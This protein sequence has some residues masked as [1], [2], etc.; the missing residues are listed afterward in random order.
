M[1]RLT[2]KDLLACKGARKLT[3]VAVRNAREAAACEAAGI[4]ILGASR[5]TADVRAIRAAAPSCFLIVGIGYGR[6]N[7]VEDALEV[8]FALLRDGVDAIYCGQSMDYVEALAKEG[9]PVVGHVGMVPY[10]RT[11]SGGFKAVGKTL[12]EALALFDLVKAYEN[13]GA[14]AVEM[15]LVPERVAAA[16]TARVKL[17]TFGMGAGSGCDAQYLFAT[18]ILGDNEGHIPRHAKVYRDHRSEYE[19]LHLDSIAAFKEFRADV[20][21]G[22]YPERKHSIRNEDAMFEAFEA[23]IKSG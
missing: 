16:I 19:R 21:N 5:L 7:A 18:D 6:V 20:L 9:V 2:V 17:L 22:A 15:E 13:A 1:A 11:W 10:K 4:D 3:Q 8:S 23:E 12:D 14:I